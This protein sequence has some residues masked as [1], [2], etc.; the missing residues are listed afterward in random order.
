M[1]TQNN[2]L[3]VMKKL[4]H[5]LAHKF[6][7]W[8]V[9]LP[10]AWSG[11]YKEDTQEL[12]RRQYLT[13]VARKDLQT[14]ID[15]LNKGLKGVD[16]AIKLIDGKDPVAA[17]N[18]HVVDGDTLGVTLTLGSKTIYIPFGRKGEDGKTPAFNVSIGT[19]GYWYI[20]GEKTE[21]RAKGDTGDVGDDGCT[22]V[23]GARQ[24]P[25]NVQDKKLYWY[26]TWCDGSTEF[27][28]NDG[29]KVPTTGEKG[30]PGVISPIS[31]V[32]INDDG[33]I[34][35]VTTL[36][37]V[38]S[39]TIPM[40]KQVSFIIHPEKARMNDADAFDRYDATSNSLLFN[41]ENERIEIP[42]ET[43]EE[44]VQVSSNL[45]RGWSYEVD[46][47]AKKIFI[48]SPVYGWGGD[49]P[50]HVDV[51]IF[52]RDKDGNTYSRPL[53][54]N[55]KA[56][57]FFSYYFQDDMVIAQYASDASYNTPTTH[58]NTKVNHISYMF[59][60]DK[61]GWTEL[62]TPYTFLVERQDTATLS[63]KFKQRVYRSF[64]KPSSFDDA[65][66][67]LAEMV[68]DPDYVQS[69]YLGNKLIPTSACLF[70]KTLDM[71]DK[72]AE[73]YY[74]KPIPFDTYFS[75]HPLNFKMSS[76]QEQLRVLRATNEMRLRIHDPNDFFGLPAD[77]K[78]DVSKVTIK[79]ISP[80]AIRQFGPFFVDDKLSVTKVDINTLN[81]V[82]KKPYFELDS[83]NDLMAWIPCFR[84]SG[85][86]Q[87]KVIVEYQKDENTRLRMLMSKDQSKAFDLPQGGGYVYFVYNV[88][89]GDFGKYWMKV[90]D[91]TIGSRTSSLARH[92]RY[93]TEIP[94]NA[95]YEIRQPLSWEN[96]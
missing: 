71:S 28:L 95:Y 93:A 31:D 9:S 50:H 88:P 79:F 17:V 66:F 36:P 85:D 60:I 53:N 24:D 54:L 74:Q 55:L 48:T 52:A 82:T 32:V 83:D 35:L 63:A 64:D 18:Y 20:N 81:P 44:L 29:Q 43:T 11:C 77:H 86:F 59:R 72:N 8:A 21:H 40:L 56:K 41:G 70:N 1:F 27:I 10:L 3:K 58:R 75:I 92:P 37:E 34:T 62:G 12:L 94:S 14:V 90:Y 22:P 30:E 61:N 23:L 25:D 84:F 91:P 78:F 87:F 45:P 46:Q 47:A 67:A 51:T 80:S 5:K 15:S 39:V 19:D 2:T 65:S 13:S 49:T 4:I 42:F 16:D 57:V 73:Y 26:V 69:S 68:Y 76:E 33:S 38:G 89:N 6:I 7:I 96:W